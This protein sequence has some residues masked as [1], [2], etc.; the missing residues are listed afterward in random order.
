MSHPTYLTR[1]FLVLTPLLP[2]ALLLHGCNGGSPVDPT[3]TPIPET[4]QAIGTV[5]LSDVTFVGK[6]GTV[7]GAASGVLIAP[8]YII[9]AAHNVADPSRNIQK[10]FNIVFGSTTYPISNSSQVKVHPNYDGSSFGSGD[11]AIVKLDTP[12]TGVTP[13]TRYI[14]T[15]E[16]GKEVVHRGFGVR[17]G[18]NDGKLGYN[19]IDGTANLLNP[20]GFKNT[21]QPQATITNATPLCLISDYDDGNTSNN[22]LTALGSANTPMPQEIMVTAGDSGAGLLV[23]TNNGLRLV[24][25]AVD[26]AVRDSNTNNTL[27][28]VYGRVSSYTRISQYKDWIDAQMTN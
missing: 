18:N 5:N 11:L 26:L 13:V 25:I 24:G 8:Q 21:E 4:I 12:V 27:E 7:N 6:L 20:L 2:A 23:R 19:V 3:P 14:G 9:T 16:I 10:P 17:N 15:G 1:L 28:N 22:T